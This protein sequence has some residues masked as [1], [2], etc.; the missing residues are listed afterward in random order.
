[1]ARAKTQHVAEDRRLVRATVAAKIL[2][3]T[4]ETLK[5]ERHSPTWG[6][7]WVR[8]GRR[9]VRYDF[10]ELERYIEKRTV[11]PAPQSARGDEDGAPAA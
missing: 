5:Q 2:D 8:H 7:P 3:T 6:L 4:E 9:G 1:M 11:R 10:R